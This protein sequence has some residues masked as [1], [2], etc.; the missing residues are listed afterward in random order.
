YDSAGLNRR[1]LQ[2]LVKRKRRRKRGEQPDEK[3][4]VGLYLETQVKETMERFVNLPF[5]RPFRVQPHIEVQLVPAGHLLGAAH[6]IL[7]VREGSETK[8]IGFSGDLGRKNYPLLVDPAPMP[9]VDY[10]VCES[11]YGSRHHRDSGDPIDWLADV[12][13]RTCIDQPGRLIVPAFSVGR[14]QA[15]LYTLN[16]LYAERNFPEVNVFAD[17]PLALKSTRV[18]ERHVRQLNPAARAFHDDHDSVFDFESLHYVQDMQKS[19]ELSNYQEPSVLVSSSGMIRGGRIEQHI[20]VNLQNPYCTILMIGYAAENTVGGQLMR[21]AKS[22]RIGQEELEVSANIETTD[23][24]S[25]HGDLEDL[26]DYIGQQ[27]PERLKGVFLT[28]GE[29]PASMQH[30]KGE[31]HARGYERVELPAKGESFEL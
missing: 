21:G 22:V 4:T 24:F 29:Y 7:K 25:G 11:T 27:A 13:K 17:S 12:I 5:G 15:L 26:L 20:K 6:V 14:T 19:R 18:Y 30:F 16:R 10:L 28:H 23:I 8:S 3:A 2:R 9:P 31:L 1:K